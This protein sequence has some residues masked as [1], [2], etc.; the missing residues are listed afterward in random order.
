MQSNT[1]I[2][3]ASA[4]L[5]NFLSPPSAFYEFDNIYDN[6]AWRGKCHWTSNTLLALNADIIALQEVFSLTETKQLFIDMGY[7]FFA[8]VDTAHIEQEYIYTHPVVAIASKFPIVQVEALECNLALTR[9]Y[10]LP[11]AAFSRT[12]LRAIINVPAIGEICVYVCHLKSQRPTDSE[13]NEQHSPLIGSWVSSQQ[14]SLEALMLRLLMEE[15]YANHP[16]PTVLM[17]DMNQTLQSDTS[18]WLTKP[19]GVASE[20]LQLKDSWDIFTHHEEKQRPATHYHF[21]KGNVL[22]YILLSQEFHVG[23]PFCCFDVIDITV[24]DKH[25]INPSY[26]IDKYASDHAFIATTVEAYF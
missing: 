19:M 26:E 23:S 15:Y 21:A 16:I 17:G 4:N 11:Q 6:D 5:F 12:P 7:P 2:T 18:G 10:S 8:T 3:F 1:K 25:L 22:D 9:G 20:R 24:Q 14:R 13:E